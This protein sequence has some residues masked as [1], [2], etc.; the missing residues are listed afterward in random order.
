MGATGGFLIP[1][2]IGAAGGLLASGGRD[3]SPSPQVPPG[4]EFLLPLLEQL[5]QGLPGQLQGTIQDTQAT[6][7]PFLQ[8]LS[9]GFP[10][11]NEGLA[12]GFTPDVVPQLREALLP[13]LE[14][15]QSR[16][17]G[18]T[19]GTAASLGT[20]TGSGT[21]RAV[22]DVNAQLEAALLGQLGQAG[23]GAAL[24]GQQIRGQLAGQASPTLAG[25]TAGPLASLSANLPFQ[26][27]QL[28]IS[29]A[30]G[31]PFSQPVQGPSKFESILPAAAQ[32]GSAY[33]TS[34]S[35]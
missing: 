23:T 4:L 16:A 1:A 32:L 31:T 18:R 7:D 33:L 10:A 5:S 22:G 19:L 30:A 9:T 11:F 26:L 35:G 6:V 24:Q 12:T 2:A 34:R 13:E 25:A 3:Q 29:G 28:I 27:A 14:L 20:L 15:A 17:T 21:T 8:A